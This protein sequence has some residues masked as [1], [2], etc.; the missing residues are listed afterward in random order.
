MQV[1]ATVWINGKMPATIVRFYKG[2]VMV[3]FGA[4]CRYKTSIKNIVKENNKL[5]LKSEI[6]N[7]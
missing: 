1:G 3:K 4:T 6:F 5:I 7:F 2:M